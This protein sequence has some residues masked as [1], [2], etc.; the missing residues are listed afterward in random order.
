[1]KMANAAATHRVAHLL[2]GSGKPREEATI[3]ASFSIMIDRGVGEGAYCG[4]RGATWCEWWM[5]GY[6]IGAY[7]NSSISTPFSVRRSSDCSAGMCSVEVRNG[8]RRVQKARMGR[9]YSPNL[10]GARPWYSADVGHGVHRPIRVCRQSIPTASLV[11]L[12]V[13]ACISMCGCFGRQGL[14]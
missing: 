10:P 9:C 13:R 2:S 3:V 7:H 4:L 14:L 6:Q 11:G 5:R 12:R 8:G 1:M